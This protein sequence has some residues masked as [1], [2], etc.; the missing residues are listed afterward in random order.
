MDQNSVALGIGGERLMWIYEKKLQFPVKIKNPDPAF[1]KLIIS[2]VGGPDGELGASTRYMQQRYSMPDR[3][4]AGMLTDIATEELGHIEM[5]SAMIYQL[6]KCLSPEEIKKSGFDVYFID[7]TT[8]VYPTA[9]SGFPFSASEFQVKGEPLMTHDGTLVGSMTNDSFVE[10]PGKQINS[11]VVTSIILYFSNSDGTELMKETRE[12]HYSTNISMEKLVLEQLI[13]GPKKSG[14]IATVPSGTKLIS[15][16]TVDGICYVNFSDTFK[17]QG[18]VI[19]EEIL[20]YSIVNSLTELPGVAKVQI[21]ING[22]TKGFVKYSYDLSK[23]YERNF[24]LLPK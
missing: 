13:E 15:V 10:N 7:H 6:T 8:G 11:S 14:A 5:V 18:A 4:V 12:V 20:L 2:Q 22:D 21:S 19:T 16:S 23:M 9:A 1:A 3:R 17:N 24:D